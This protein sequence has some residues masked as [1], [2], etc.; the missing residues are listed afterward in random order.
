MLGPTGLAIGKVTIASKSWHFNV[1]GGVISN[2]ARTTSVKCVHPE[3]I[4]SHE[5]TMHE[6]ENHLANVNLYDALHNLV[7]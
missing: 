4:I 5:N 2:Y 6:L 7:V 3:Q 1:K